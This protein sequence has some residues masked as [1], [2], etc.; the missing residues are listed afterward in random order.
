[1]SVILV[2]IFLFLVSFMF[3]YVMSARMFTWGAKAVVAAVLW[4]PIVA[5]LLLQYTE[6]I[7]PD[8][9]SLIAF[10]KETII[11]PRVLRLLGS[12]VYRTGAM[13]PLPC[14]LRQ[15][16]AVPFP[17][18]LSLSIKSSAVGRAFL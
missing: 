14:A 10:L 2:P 16:A 13:G 7:E 17:A 8:T 12:W 1:M 3:G 9:L 6:V 15:S 11:P 18:S 4:L 5:L